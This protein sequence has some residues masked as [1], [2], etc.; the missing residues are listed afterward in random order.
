MMA[1]MAIPTMTSAILLAPRAMAAARDYF[2][3]MERQRTV[4]SGDIH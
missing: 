4:R 1:L 2:G 3:R